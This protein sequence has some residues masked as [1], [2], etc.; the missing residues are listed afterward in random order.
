MHDFATMYDFF[1][2][3]AI[4]APNVPIKAALY[5]ENLV[6]TFV[7]IAKTDSNFFNFICIARVKS[8]AKRMVSLFLT[9]TYINV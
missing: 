9:K 8:R 2:T 4:I 1:M 7:T 3:N 6:A 5:T